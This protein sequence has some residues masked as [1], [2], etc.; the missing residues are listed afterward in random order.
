MPIEYEFAV[1]S[2]GILS[3]GAQGV[4]CTF[5]SDVVSG[6]V[7]AAFVSHGDTD[8]VIPSSW[9]TVS[10]SSNSESGYR[11]RMQ[12]RAFVGGDSPTYVFSSAGAAAAYAVIARLRG[13]DIAVGSYLRTSSYNIANVANSIGTLRTVDTYWAQNGYESFVIT[14]A[15]YFTNNIVSAPRGFVEAMRVSSDDGLNVSLYAYLPEVL[16]APFAPGTYVSSVATGTAFVA[17]YAFKG[18]DLFVSSKHIHVSCVAVTSDN[19][20]IDWKSFVYPSGAQ[21]GDLIIAT[22]MHGNNVGISTFPNSFVLVQSYQDSNNGSRVTCIAGFFNTGDS[23]TVVVSAASNLGEFIGA[24]YRI[25]HAKA[26][27]D[28][29]S[30]I[31]YTASNASTTANVNPPAASTLPF[32]H[33]TVLPIIVGKSRGFITSI[34]TEYQTVVLHT[35]FSAGAYGTGYATSAERLHR[36]IDPS[37]WV[38]S[39]SSNAPQHW[40]TVAVVPWYASTPEAALIM[41][42]VFGSN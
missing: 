11:F 13:V 24:T 6:D 20:A 30:A 16:D 4:N 14:E 34:S 28:V 1:T 19:S 22:W 2:I 17:A 27:W 25:R 40:A 29:K 32:K 31:T 8:P 15:Q 21:S 18:R 3:A 23:E 41:Y 5:P 42:D 9:T 33:G 26:Q 12:T 36:T 35:A 37:T 39:N 7:L 10:S 38:A